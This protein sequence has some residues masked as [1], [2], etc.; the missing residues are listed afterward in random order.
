[1]ADVVAYGGN[2]ATQGKIQAIAA[3]DR[4][5][6]KPSGADDGRSRPVREAAM[7]LLKVG[8]SITVSVSLII[9]TCVAKCRLLG[10]GL[11]GW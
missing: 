6:A 3:D 5:R 2:V 9:A 11:V 10:Q 4:P 8:D 7:G 1:M